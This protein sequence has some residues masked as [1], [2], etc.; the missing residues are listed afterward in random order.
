MAQ[1]GR[2]P[3]GLWRAVARGLGELLVTAGLVV[4]LFVVY[5]VHVTDLLNDRRQAELA[6]EVDEAWTRQPAGASVELVEPPLG[7][8]VA[9]LRIPRLGADHQRVVLQGT[10]E[11]QLSQGPGHYVGTALPGQQGNLAIAGHRVGKGSPFLDLDRMRPG[12]PIVVETA[13]S[14]FVY[15]VLG[16]PA[17]GDVADPSGVPGLHVVR[18]E[19]VGVIAPTPGAPGTAASGAYLTLTTCHPRYSARQ[20]LVVHAVL[21]GTAISKADAPDGPPGLTGG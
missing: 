18:P 11:D 4:L 13:G 5:E 15:R 20:R 6:E 3:A 7:E 12:D 16:N 1:A 2:T 19:E 10:S 17:N 8:P 21:D 9:V 14:W